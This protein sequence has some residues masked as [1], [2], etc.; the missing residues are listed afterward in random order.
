[1]IVFIGFY[2]NKVKTSIKHYLLLDPEPPLLL[3]EDRAGDEKEEWLDA[4]ADTRV[5]GADVLLGVEEGWLL[6]ETDREGV[7]TLLFLEGA[8]WLGL[9]FC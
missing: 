6:G 3:P 2:F 9:E 1:M 4:G 8:A 5:A 7:E